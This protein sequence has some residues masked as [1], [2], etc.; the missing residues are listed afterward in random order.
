MDELLFVFNFFSRISAIFTS[1]ASAYHISASL[2]DQVDQYISQQKELSDQRAKILVLQ[3]RPHFIYNTMM[4]IYYLCAQNS[5]KAQQV[6]LDFS[7]YLR[8]NFTAITKKE[9]VPFSEELEHTR[10]YLAVEQV[11]FVLLRKMKV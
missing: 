10:A 2:L 3:M 7:I 11:R 5:Q 1:D 9:T 8:K 4:S 6:I